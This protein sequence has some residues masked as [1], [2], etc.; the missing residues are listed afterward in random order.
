[1]R[2]QFIRSRSAI[3]CSGL[4]QKLL[5]G[6]TMS[7]S[8]TKVFTTTTATTIFSRLYSYRGIDRV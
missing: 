8:R 2:T 4:F 7:E 6:L 5:C 1:M 3:V